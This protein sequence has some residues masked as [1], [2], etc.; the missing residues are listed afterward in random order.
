MTVGDKI[1]SM[2]DEEL[3]E[4][5]NDFAI[6]IAEKTAVFIGSY[7]KRVIDEEYGEE[8]LTLLKMEDI[9]P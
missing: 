7:S 4:F 9:E 8:L 1:R 6:D 3:A 5:L 2:T